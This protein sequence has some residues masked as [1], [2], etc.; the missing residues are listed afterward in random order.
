MSLENLQERFPD[1]S[2]VKYGGERYCGMRL[3]NNGIKLYTITG[4]YDMTIRDRITYMVVIHEP[5][6]TM[7]WISMVENGKVYPWITRR[8]VK[9]IEEFKNRIK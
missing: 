8:V 6:G 4:D 3:Q 5:S 1:Y 2:S 9:L 7:E